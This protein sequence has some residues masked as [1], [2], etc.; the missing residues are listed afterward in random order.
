MLVKERL[1]Q[2]LKS[3]AMETLRQAEAAS[4][5]RLAEQPHALQFG[6]ARLLQMQG[7]IKGAVPICRRA[8]EGYE[9]MH[10]EHRESEIQTHTNTPLRI[11]DCY[12]LIGSFIPLH[13][14]VHAA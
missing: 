8:L 7:D 5:G 2:W 14:A 11:I 10:Q 13:W 9:N 6:V 1:R 4:D 3:S 12:M